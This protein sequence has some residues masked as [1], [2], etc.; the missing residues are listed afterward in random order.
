MEHDSQSGRERGITPVIGVIM[1]VAITVILAS[2]F[3]VYALGLGSG[4]ADANP[5]DL[6]FDFDYDDGGSDALTVTFKAGEVVDAE[7]LELVVSDAG[8]DD[9]RY[10]FTDD[11]SA[12][13][14]PFEAEEHVTLEDT[15][16]GVTAPLDLSEATV[17]VVWTSRD[18]N[19]DATRSSTVAVWT[20]PEA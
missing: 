14:G 9:G 4:V 12:T 11:L 2:V 16:G 19:P 13:A 7:R 20:G 3:G 15:A 1:V 10:S 6:S 8:D 5:P 18:T 17:R